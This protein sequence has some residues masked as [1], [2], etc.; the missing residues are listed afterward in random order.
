MGARPPPSKIHKTQQQQPGRSLGKLR[1]DGRESIYFV[2]TVGETPNGS[3]GMSC[4]KLSSDLSRK[5]QSRLTSY[6][7]GW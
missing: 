3:I 6:E 2:M 4:A 5:V 7:G 1:S